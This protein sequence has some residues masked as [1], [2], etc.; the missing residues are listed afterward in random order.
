ML[1][2]VKIKDKG[3]NR[4]AAQAL[5]KVNTAIYSIIFI[6]SVVK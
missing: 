3:L 1:Y 5:L 2:N 4:S 6:F